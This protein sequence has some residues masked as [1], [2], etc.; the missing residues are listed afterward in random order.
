MIRT[1]T[2][3]NTVNLTDIRGTQQGEDSHS[4]QLPLRQLTETDSML[5]HNLK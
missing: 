1:T 3:N 5:G 4:F 2:K